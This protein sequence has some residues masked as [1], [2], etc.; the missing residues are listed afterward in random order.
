MKILD[1]TIRD[2]GHLNKWKFSTFCVKASYYAALKAGID[3]FEFGYRNADT[4]KN[5]GDFGYCRDHF[6]LGL[7]PPSGKCKPTVMIDAGKSD[8]S[9]FS[10]CKPEHTPIHAVRIAAYPYELEK[11]I[12]LVEALHGKGYEVFLNLMAASEITGP[13]LDVLRKWNAKEI[14]E[15]VYFADSFGSFLPADIPGHLRTLRDIGFSRIGFHPHNNLQLAFANT[16]KAIEEG[17]T[18]VDASIYGMGRGSGNLPIEVLVGYLEKS[19]QTQY[20]PI[21]YLA[22]I[23]RYYEK[24]FKD[25]DWGYK[26]KS[27][28]GGLKNIHPYYVDDLFDRRNYTVDEIWNALDAIKE[29]CPISYSAAKLDETLDSR[30]YKPL[31]EESASV[32]CQ[33]V[34]DQLKIIPASDAF[35]VGD[36]ALRNKHVGKKFIIIANGPSLLAYKSKIQNLIADEGCVTIG[37]N[38]LQNTIT[39][40]YHLFV[41]RK[42]FLKYVQFVSKQSVLLVPS[43]FGR[44][45]IDE[46]Y[47][48]D[49][50]YFDVDTVSDR[51]T[52]SVVGTTQKCCNLNV[53][54]SSILCAYL[55]GA[56]EILTVGMD[57]YVDELNKKM[58]Y[59]YNEN[60]TPDNKEVA[61]Y[62]YTMLAEELE[63]VNL[64]LQDKS[65][66]FAIITPTTHVKYYRKMLS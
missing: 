57:G 21:P 45:I 23:E 22:V 54:V 48:G 2:G 30:F 66:P 65:V 38:Y 15:A 60:D 1:C 13:Q 40:D 33:E 6:L 11:A 37:V 26:I 51:S 5:L 50:C 25:L 36:F 8:S 20:N 9:L 19:G 52:P 59:F 7:V 55:M 32:V 10:D 18:H 35:R 62:R 63:R 42:R 14:L 49:R 31:K 43:F 3:Y 4:V 41:S 34:Q 46:N 28:L 12:D 53:A 44:T 58:V 64:F 24:L 29:K 27:L 39:P 16:L 47:E 56:S 61:S 17:A